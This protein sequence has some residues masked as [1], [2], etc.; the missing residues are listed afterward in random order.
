MGLIVIAINPRTP[1]NPFPP[2]ASSLVT[3]SPSAMPVTRRP[4]PDGVS[5]LATPAVRPTPTLLALD[6]PTPSATPAA[7]FTSTVEVRAVPDCEEIVVAGTVRDAEGEPLEGYPVHLWGPVG[8]EILI[9]GSSP[10]YGAGGWAV[11]LPRTKV[12]MFSAWFIQLHQHNVYRSHPSLSSIVEV[13]LSGDCEEGLTLIHFRERTDL[14]G[15][16]P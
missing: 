16:V 3:P 5:P 4:T 15:G 11:A 12:P 10:E 8:E 6:M 14:L 13:R 1:L 9:S 7:P 2:P